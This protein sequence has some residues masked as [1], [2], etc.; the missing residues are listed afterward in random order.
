MK[1]YILI[2]IATLSLWQCKRNTMPEY[3]GKIQPHVALAT[4]STQSY[5]L[6]IPKSYFTNK[7][8]GLLLAFDPEANGK[9]PVSLLQ[10]VAEKFN[11]IVAGSNVSKNGENIVKIRKHVHA[12]IDELTPKYA[13]NEN[14]IYSIGFSGGAKVAG[15]IAGENAEISGT[16]ACS[17]LPDDIY[18]FL[19][20]KDFLLLTIVGN[21]DFNYLDA[22]QIE[23]HRNQ[24]PLK[25]ELITFNGTHEWPDKKVLYEA[26]ILL[27]LH[28]MV[29]EK[30]PIDSSKLTALIDTT[31]KIANTHLAN[32]QYLLGYDT[33]KRFYK[34]AYKIMNDAET[35]QLQKEMLKIYD[36]PAYQ[37][38][39]KNTPTILEKEIA[40]REKISKLFKAL[41]DKSPDKIK[42]DI[43]NITKYYESLKQNK[44][45]SDTLL[46]KR[47]QAYMGILCYAVNQQHPQQQALQQSIDFLQMW[48]T[49]DYKQPQPC[50]LLA[51]KAAAENKTDEAFA[52]LNEAAN[53]K[54]KNIEQL[55][56]NKA[57]IPLHQQAQWQDLLKKIQ[58]NAE[59]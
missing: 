45:I 27:T 48:K 53:R 29:T 16:I 37:E 57:F 30:I 14:R 2:I 56:N 11:F 36:N 34:Y 59:N 55:K 51:E 20:K 40:E 50:I 28:E 6:Y 52:L 39:L 8:V 33:Y 31:Q 17:G 7:N 3:Y 4:D 5:A 12:L 22:L 54:Y 23:Q 47:L 19:K 9:K 46:I 25:H 21:E 43:E 38:Q 18:M 44:E 58:Q 10:D 42:P 41:L 15:A 24:T 26:F 13:I 35:R 49:I 32:T 1:K